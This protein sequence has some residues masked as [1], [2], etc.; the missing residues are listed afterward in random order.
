MEKIVLLCENSVEGMLTAVYD[1][2]VIKNEKFSGKEP[3][4]EV[5]G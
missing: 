5:S 1:G 2:F 3:F 4:R